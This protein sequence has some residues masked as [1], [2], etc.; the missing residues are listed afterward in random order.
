MFKDRQAKLTFLSFLS[1]LVVI[2][3]TFTGISVYAVVAKD[4][5]QMTTTT[6]NSAGTTMEF[7]NNVITA[8]P[9]SDTSARSNTPQ[10]M[11]ADENTTTSQANLNELFNGLVVCNLGTAN[12]DSNRTQ[13]VT[14]DNSSA[15]VIPK[16]SV[17]IL[18]E[19]ELASLAS[20]VTKGISDNNT[21][22]ATVHCKALSK[23]TPTG[24]SISANNSTISNGTEVSSSPSLNNSNTTTTNSEKKIAVIQ[25][26]D[27]TSGQVVL[28]FSRN[29][30]VA[31]DDVNGSGQ[32]DA[33]VPVASLG[34]EIKFVESGTNRTATFEFNGNDLIPAAQGKIVSES[35][36]P[37]N[38][39]MTTSATPSGN[40]AV[41]SAPMK[42]NEENNSNSIDNSTN[43][44]NPASM[45]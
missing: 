33:R 11:T 26:Q 39:N 25:G 40:A 17:K 4:D 14:V 19:S 8:Q 12:I 41:S 5:S 30:L 38:Q 2:S 42:I 6:T 20:N 29:A 7:S 44:S 27:F 36:S 24:S 23:G 15:S 18:A 10:M 13:T 9:L 3:T 28:V 34:N 1:A 45:Q 43:N 22:T 16:V 37:T 21:S 35:S 31:I 32:I